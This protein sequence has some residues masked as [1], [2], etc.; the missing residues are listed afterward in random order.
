VRNILISH[1]T[2]IS[3]ITRKT[4]YVQRNIEV[5]SRNHCCH[6]NDVTIFTA[7]NSRP[8]VLF[9]GCVTTQPVKTGPIGCPETSVRNYNYSL[10]NN[11][12]EGSYNLLR[13]GSP[14]ITHNTISIMAWPD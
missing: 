2:K 14:P 1:K 9:I 8:W 4:V 6:G 3:E 10:R 7:R 11:P 12:E 5:R 13:G